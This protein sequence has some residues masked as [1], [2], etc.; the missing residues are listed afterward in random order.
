MGPRVTAQSNIDSV[1]TI[2]IAFSKEL[3]FKDRVYLYNYKTNFV[4]EG[5]SIL[6]LNH[7]LSAEVIKVALFFFTKD[8]S[9]A[10]ILFAMESRGYKPADLDVLME[11]GNNFIPRQRDFTAA[12]LGGSDIYHAYKLKDYN[13]DKALFNQSFKSRQCGF[14]ALEKNPTPIKATMRQH[15][16]PRCSNG[17]KFTGYHPNERSMSPEK[18]PKETTSLAVFMFSDN[19]SGKA[20]IEEMR[21][22][23]YEPAN[24]DALIAFSSWLFKSISCPELQAKYV[25]V[26][27]GSISLSDDKHIICPTATFND[28]GHGIE[29]ATYRDQ[30]FAKGLNC[31]FLGFQEE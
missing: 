28:F 5:Q 10:E 29:S 23:G 1:Q 20:I 11:F 3:P 12:V 8:V 31:A 17:V 25:I 7:P 16:V 26:G 13:L 2:G 30:L 27:F 19:L 24:H 14:L 4:V 6:P 9:R 21:G 22:V 18:E 15:M